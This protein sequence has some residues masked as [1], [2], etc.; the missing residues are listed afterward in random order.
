[1]RSFASLNLDG[2]SA[3]G[4]QQLSPFINF[5]KLYKLTQGHPC[6]KCEHKLEC[7]A[8]SIHFGDIGLTNKELSRR[9]G[10]SLNEVR[11][12]KEEGYYDNE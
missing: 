8:R 6:R 11:R 3:D 4:C 1:M 7:K 12:R 9:D 2:L 10:I 5:V